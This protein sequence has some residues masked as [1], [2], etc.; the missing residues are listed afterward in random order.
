M[1]KE[2]FIVEFIKKSGICGICGI[3]KFAALCL[4]AYSLRDSSPRQ[5]TPAY[6]CDSRPASNRPACLRD[7]INAVCAPYSA[8]TG[9]YEVIPRGGPQTITQGLYELILTICAAA[10]APACLCD[11]LKHNKSI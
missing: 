11:K 2:Q 10:N 4:C 8:L 7:H 3:L 9:A 6:F 1:V 5:T